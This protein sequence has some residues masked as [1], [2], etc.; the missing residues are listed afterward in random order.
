MGNNRLYL[1][2]YGITI[3]RMILDYFFLWL[4]FFYLQSEMTDLDINA[5]TSDRGSQKQLMQP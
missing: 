1:I 2:N 3:D 4:L 5:L